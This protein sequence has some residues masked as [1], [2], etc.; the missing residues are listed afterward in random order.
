MP[1]PRIAAVHSFSDSVVKFLGFGEHAGAVVPT[2][3]DLE[4]AGTD[5]H[6]GLAQAVKLGR[7]LVKLILDDAR[8]VWETQCIWGGEAMMLNKMLPGRT[9]EFVDIVGAAV[10]PHEDWPALV[11]Q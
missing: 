10:T 3:D 7:P 2:A 6:P 8:V 4:P 11:G 5:K 9:A 1:A